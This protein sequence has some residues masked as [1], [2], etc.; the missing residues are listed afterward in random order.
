MLYEIVYD[1]YEPS[2]SETGTR[3][4]SAADNLYGM[5]GDCEDEK[6]YRYL[7]RTV[8]ELIFIRYVK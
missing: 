4:M 7:I 2:I 6:L 5:N 1:G 8:E 3:S